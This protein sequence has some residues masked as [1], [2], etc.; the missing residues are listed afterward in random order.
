MKYYSFYYT[1]FQGTMKK[2]LTEHY[3]KSFVADTMRHGKRYG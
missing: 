3:G 2:V 1:L